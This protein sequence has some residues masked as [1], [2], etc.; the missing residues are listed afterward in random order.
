MPGVPMLPP[1]L[2]PGGLAAL[3][4]SMAGAKAGGGGGEDSPDGLME[5]LSAAEELHK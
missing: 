5:L 2:M 4:H 3:P 1:H